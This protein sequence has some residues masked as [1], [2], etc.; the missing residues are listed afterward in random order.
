MGYHCLQYMVTP[1]IDPKHHGSPAVC[2]YHTTTICVATHTTAPKS[3]FSTR[4]C[5]ASHDKGVARLLLPF[6]DLPYAQICLQSSMRGIICD[7]ELG[8]PRV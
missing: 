2:P 1:S 3:H 5:S 4:Q 6:L 8:I 7:G